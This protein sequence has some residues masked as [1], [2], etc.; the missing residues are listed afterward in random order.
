MWLLKDQ[1]F[2]DIVSRYLIQKAEENPAFSMQVLQKHKTI[3]KCMNYIME[4][5]YSIAQKE[6][7]KRV[8][9]KQ[10]VTG[11]E[12]NVAL[13]ISEIQ[14]YQWAEDYYALDDAKQEADKKEKE[15]KKRISKQKKSVQQ[16]GKKKTSVKTSPTIPAKNSAPAPA[17]KKK[18][19]NI[20]LSMF[21]MMQLDNE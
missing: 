6:H 8:N 21:D 13:G 14:V 7:E 12:Q 16:N 4:Q 9:G 17:K 20:Q 1:M 5:A 10:P 11:R 15:Q 3:Q 18:E 2:T 19:E